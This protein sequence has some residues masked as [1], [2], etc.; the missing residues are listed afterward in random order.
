MQRKKPRKPSP[1]KSASEPPPLSPLRSRMIEDMEL[2]G[3]ALRTQQAYVRSVVKLQEHYQGK[4]PDRITEKEVRAYL[5]WLRDEKNCSRGR[6]YPTLYGLKFFYQRCL[7]R[8]WGLFNKKSVRKPKKTRLPKFVHLDQ[9]RA[10]I[11]GLH[12]LRYK[13]FASSIFALGLRVDDAARIDIRN[14]DGEH[15]LIRVIG[16]GNKERILPL[17][18]PLYHQMRKLW[19]THRHPHLLFTNKKGTAPIPIGPFRHAFRESCRKAGLPD[20]V[21]PHSLRHGFATVLLQNEVP[22]NQVQELLGHSDIKTTQIY[23]HLTEAMRD[24]IR[25]KLDDLCR[26]IGLPFP[27]EKGKGGSGAPLE[28]GGEHE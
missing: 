23:L 19:A 21:V 9:A 15:G 3:L 24:G 25:P 8:N 26:G 22:I 20:D 11:D 17:P 13:V 10:I 5:V 12:S 1:K 14:I 7:E 27:E 2:A 16:K 28:R 6:F 18:T 4:S